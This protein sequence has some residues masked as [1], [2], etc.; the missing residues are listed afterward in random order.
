MSEYKYVTIDE[1]GK[2]YVPASVR[3]GTENRKYLI[4]KLPN[5]EIILHPI[6]KQGTPLERLRNTLGPVKG[7]LKKIKREIQEV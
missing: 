7:D 2:L 5:G 1:S 4:L 3:E 6:N